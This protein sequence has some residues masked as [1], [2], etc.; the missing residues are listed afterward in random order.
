MS[1]RQAVFE[2]TRKGATSEQPDVP[3]VKT[4][5]TFASVREESLLLFGLL[6]CIAALAALQP[7]NAGN[8]LAGWI[9]ALGLQALPYAAAVACAW[10]SGLPRPE[11][12][13]DLAAR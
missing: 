13:S 12:R 1:R 4:P 6:G 11:T 2:V 3:K 8:A 10:L 5:N 9:L 7:L